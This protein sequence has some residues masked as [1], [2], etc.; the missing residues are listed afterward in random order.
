M[1]II[2]LELNEV[3]DRVMRQ[4]FGT[5]IFG[6]Y[7]SKYNLTIS[8]DIGSLS[9]WITWATVHRGVTN[10]F[11][12]INDI[13][14]NVDDIDSKYPTLF[15]SCIDRGLSVGIV[16][17]MHSGILADRRDRSYK[18]LLPE[19]FST[20][21][22]CIP[23]SLESFQKFNLAMSRASSR[24]VSTHL[25]KKLN[26]IKVFL[27][28]LKNTKRTRAIRI[29]VKQLISE[30]FL[31]QRK[32]RR[33]TIQSDLIFDIFVS[34]VKKNSPDLSVIFT[35]HVASAM[36]RFWEATYPEDYKKQVS[37]DSWIKT[38]KDEI[39]FSMK[40]AKEYINI[41][42]SIVDESEDTQLWIASSMGQE[43]FQ[44][45]SPKD[46]FWDIYNMNDYV[47]SC[48]GKEV[49]VR[50]LPQMIPLYSFS[51]EKEIIN[52]FCE[53]IKSADNLELRKSTSTTIAFGIDN[54]RKE[55]NL[56]ERQ[57][58]PKGIIKKGIDEKTSSAAYHMPEG[59]LLRY[60][61]S[62]TEI[63]KKII[64]KNGY[65]PTHRIKEFVL[66]TLSD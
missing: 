32:V 20:S 30:I 47:S 37:S 5:K 21:S 27:S 24:V 6:R 48:L 64:N 54:Q 53:F 2:F 26:L 4:F 58:I 25:P 14:Q 52:E 29:I 45:Y 19:A 11:H 42:K 36:H 3:P 8:E 15:K 61:P 31:P 41:L 13:N 55:I 10:K 17:T 50:T 28:Y 49:K 33:R 62:L 63:N 43:S 38:Y 7:S 16:N 40:S 35:N 9:P 34:L 56:K 60:G 44:K 23:K 65:L 51:A 66:S 57:I 18:F 12:G 1:K 22:F 59:F 39:S 46:Y